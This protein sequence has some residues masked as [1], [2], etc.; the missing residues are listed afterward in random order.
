MGNCIYKSK[1]EPTFFESRETKFV[2]IHDKDGYHIYQYIKGTSI[3]HGEQEHY[4]N[5]N[6]YLTET[7]IDGQLNGHMIRRTTPDL[8]EVLN[9]KNNKLDGP[10]LYYNSIG[11][12][13]KGESY[14]DGEL[15]Y[16]KLFD[17]D[18]N[19]NKYSK[20]KNGK[21]FEEITYFNTPVKSHSIK[22]YDNNGNLI[23]FQKVENDKLIICLENGVYQEWW[24][25][26]QIKIRANYKNNVKNGLYEEY[27]ESGQIK[28]RTN[29]E[30]DKIVGHYEEWWPNGQYK[31][32]SFIYPSS[33]NIMRFN[34]KGLVTEILNFDDNNNSKHI[35]MFN[36]SGKPSLTYTLANN[37]LNGEKITYYESGTIK[38][39]EYYENNMLHGSRWEYDENGSVK[40]TSQY[41][42]GGLITLK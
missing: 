27:Y 39:A 16:I 5:N 13:I 35:R 36:D 33:K 18:S 21:L 17:N 2:R 22:N 1:I 15:E 23:K 28:I 26:G 20:F 40:K 34:Q 8:V 32:N 19:L 12:F 6:P 37:L 24:P 42:L 14:N 11:Q 7:Y 3:K 10:Q 38:L 31:E 30:D 4:N 25:T 41:Y 29:F 9:Y